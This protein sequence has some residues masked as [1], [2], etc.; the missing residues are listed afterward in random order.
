MKCLAITPPYMSPYEFV[1]YTKGQSIDWIKQ[2]KFVI[3]DI[4]RIY[5]VN[6]I[7][8]ETLISLAIKKHKM[9]CC[10]DYIN[11]IPLEF[12]IPMWIIPKERYIA[13]WYDHMVLP[14]KVNKFQRHT[15]NILIKNGLIS[16]NYTKEIFGKKYQEYLIWAK[17]N[18]EFKP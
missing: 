8:A 11:S 10:I 7:H 18:I 1:K 17:A 9:A 13:A 16:K 4:G 15:I 3:D 14:L 5:L 12:S 2:C 6:N